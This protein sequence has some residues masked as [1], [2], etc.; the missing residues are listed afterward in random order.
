MTPNTW[1][2][3]RAANPSAPSHATRLRLPGRRVHGW[4]RTLDISSIHGLF[5]SAGRLGQVTAKTAL[6][7]R[8]RAV[9]KGRIRD[10]ATC[11]VLRPGSTPRPAI[12][13]HIAAGMAARGKTDCEAAVRDVL[14]G[15]QP[16]RR[17]V[18]PK[19]VATMVVVLCSPAGDDVTEPTLPIAGGWS[20]G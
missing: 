8:T 3:E 4:G 7:R 15:K 11:T 20:A 5:A 19:A 12:E 14:A 1:D 10:G 17:I 13:T 2:A 18:R 6:I 9:A 16:I